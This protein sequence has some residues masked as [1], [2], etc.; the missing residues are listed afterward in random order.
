MGGREEE[1]KAAEVLA[2][3]LQRCYKIGYFAASIEQSFK[4]DPPYWPDMFFL[5][6]LPRICSA[7]THSCLLPSFLQSFQA[8]FCSFGLIRREQGAR[9]CD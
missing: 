6:L 7:L 4:F 9:H 8:L 1:V 2:L 3:K 5:K